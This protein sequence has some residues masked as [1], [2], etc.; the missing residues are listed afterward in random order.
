MTKRSLILIAAVLLSG[1][2][3]KPAPALEKVL[4]GDSS[5]LS[6]AGFYIAKEKGYFTVLGIDAEIQ[7]LKGSSSDIVPLLAAGRVDVGGCALTAGFYNAVLGGATL[8][9]VADKGHV[10]PANFMAVLISKKLYPGKLTR[11]NLKGKSFGYG[12]GYPQEIFVER[13]L[14]QYGLTLD[15]V[16]QFNGSSPNFNAALASGSLFGTVQIEPYLTPA[17]SEGM[18]VEVMAAGKLYPKQQGGVVLF[19]EAFAKERRATAVKFMAAY[20][21]GCRDLNAYRRGKA[22]KKELFEILKKYTSMDDYERF[23]LL[24]LPE[25]SPEGTIN[26][27]SVKRDAQWYH[28]RGY[29][30]EV[31]ALSDIFDPGIAADALKLLKRLAPP[32]RLKK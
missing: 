16:E 8:K 30:K 12:K 10:V 22:D 32:E 4:I 24:R 20:L 19:S 28:D 14:Q 7:V 27:D 21:K 13:F 9:A 18:A 5:M 6:S 3:E 25:L 15:D 17:V 29:L 23:K 2:A 1:G 31:P 26:M 11:E